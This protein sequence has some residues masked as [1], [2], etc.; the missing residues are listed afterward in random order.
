MTAPLPS[1]ATGTHAPQ[2][3]PF[4]TSTC[5]D[6]PSSIASIDFQLAMIVAAAPAMD[7]EQL[8]ASRVTYRASVARRKELVADAPHAVIRAF[9][10]EGRLPTED[11]AVIHCACGREFSDR[12]QLGVARQHAVHAKAESLHSTPCVCGTYDRCP[13]VREQDARDV[14]HRGAG[15]AFRAQHRAYND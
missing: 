3:S 15:A 8:E 1:C 14:A 11:L 6:T 5:C 13:G 4:G 2:T 12:D 7:A 9:R 10:R